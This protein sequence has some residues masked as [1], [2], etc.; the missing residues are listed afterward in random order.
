MMLYQFVG[1][2]FDVDQI[3][4][5]HKISL[6][7]D[8]RYEDGTLENRKSLQLPEEYTE[9]GVKQKKRNPRILSH[10]GDSLYDE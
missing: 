4:D 1:D 9:S 3:S 7:D 5:K 6:F 2:A 8:S 10:H